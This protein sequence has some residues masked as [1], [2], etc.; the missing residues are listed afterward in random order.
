MGVI[1]AQL[2][3]SDTRMTERHYVHLARLTS[4]TRQ[5]GGHLP[6]LG[7]VEPNNVVPLKPKSDGA[8][9]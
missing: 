3:H 4:P 6:S 9:L 2:G 1:A 8:M 7:K 5:G